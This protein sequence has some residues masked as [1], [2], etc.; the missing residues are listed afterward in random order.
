LAKVKELKPDKPLRYIVNT[1][2]HFDHS[3]GIRRA[4]AEQGV[5]IIT[6]EGNKAF[7]EA[8]AKRASSMVPDEFSKS[9]KTPQ[10]I[11]ISDKYELKDNTRTV[12]LYPIP[13][14]HSDTML[15][16]YF[17]A[18]KLLVEADLYTPPAANAPPPPG[19]PFAPS[20]VELVQKRGLR[21][22]KLMPIHGFIVPYS[23]LVAAVRTTSKSSD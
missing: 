12:E 22:D 19:F 8:L 17:P 15:V 3:G 2:H 23:N 7:Y 4:M 21:V 1:H 14:P 10:V 18:E 11:G 5:T 6:H 16:A 13:N 9:P 20:V